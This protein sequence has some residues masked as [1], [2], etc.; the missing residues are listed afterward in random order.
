MTTTHRVMTA[1]EEVADALAALTDAAV[2]AIHGVIDLPIIDAVHAARDAL[3]RW[4]AEQT[5]I[6]KERDEMRQVLRDIKRWHVNNWVRGL[7][8]P[9]VHIRRGIEKFA[10]HID[11]EAS[12]GG[13]A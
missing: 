8:W 13:A 4:R 11:E 5:S 12:Q 9:P 6:E 7:E 1:A 2:A 10:G 3:E